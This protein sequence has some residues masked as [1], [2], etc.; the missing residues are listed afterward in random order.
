MTPAF[1]LSISLV[2]SL[3]LWVPTVP[4]A[5]A[6]QEDPAHI[7]LRY[8]LALVVSRVGVGLFFRVINAYAAAHEAALAAEAAENEPVAEDDADPAFGRRREDVGADEQVP[9]D[10]ALLDEALEEVEQTTALA[11]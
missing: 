1:R 4:G 6:S 8:L 7:A 2:A 5:I 9:D 10:Q 3:L 11:S